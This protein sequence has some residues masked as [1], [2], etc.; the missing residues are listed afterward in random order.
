MGADVSHE[1]QVRI[2]FKDEELA[3]AA[4]SALRPE[5]ERPPT[6][7]FKT[8]L[9]LEGRTLVIT[10]RAGDLSSLRAGL[11]AYLSWLK[12]IEEVCSIAR[13]AKGIS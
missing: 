11:N 1:V 8:E 5:A 6:G 10:I 12:A 13:G 2:P 3:R 4:L 7:R 9:W